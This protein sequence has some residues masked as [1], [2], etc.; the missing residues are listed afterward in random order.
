MTLITK[1]DWTVAVTVQT[2]AVA[3]P[4]HAFEVNVPIDLSP[5]FKGW[6]PIPAVR[7]VENQTGAWDHARAFRNPVLSD[8]STANEALTEYAD[9]HS[10]AYEVTNFTN[11]TSRGRPAAPSLV[12]GIR[13][14]PKEKPAARV[15][16]RGHRAPR[17]R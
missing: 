16:P 11:I 5:V 13:K 1:N 14:S 12:A 10:F 4:Q 17:C 7:R 6:G 9:G 2:R 8:G 15:T 3:P